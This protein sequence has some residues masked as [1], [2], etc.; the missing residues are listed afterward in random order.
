M[1][2]FAVSAA[3]LV[4]LGIYAA[5]Q[6]SLWWPSLVGIQGSNR[7]LLA[8]ATMLPFML[9]FISINWARPLDWLS[10]RFNR[11]LEPINRAIE[12]RGGR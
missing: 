4:G 3:T 12:K 11:A 5:L 8:A 9:L 1:A 6:F 7:M 2:A 10:A